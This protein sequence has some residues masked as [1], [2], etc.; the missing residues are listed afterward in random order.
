MK[1][2]ICV[3]A[4]L[5]VAV[6][7]AWGQTPPAE[8]AKDKW[9]HVRV[10]KAG[11]DGEFVRVNIPLSLAEAVLPTIE[12]HNVRHGKVRIHMHR[13]DID[14]RAL[15]DAVKNTGDGEFVTV[16]KKDEV[17]RVAKSQG[18]LIVKTDEGAEKGDRVDIKVPMVVVEALLSGEDD[19]L[20]LMAAIKALR[21]FGDIELVTVRSGKETVR[22]WIDSKNT[23]E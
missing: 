7:V 13:H 8:S 19:E 16:E 23:S 20:N 18:Y 17:I 2:L 10:E 14:I 21:Q 22:I 15:L 4:L 9:L 5:A 3:V 1:R 11:E 6:P 12:A